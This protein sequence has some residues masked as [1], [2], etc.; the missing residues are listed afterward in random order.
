MTQNIATLWRPIFAGKPSQLQVVV[1]TQ[2]VNADTTK[3]ILACQDTYQYVD[4]V[5]IAPYFSANLT[6]QTTLDQLLGTL[7]PADISKIN[8]TLKEH[9][10]FTTP[11]N[12]KLFCYESGQGL[13]GGNSIQMNLQIAAQ[14]DP[15]MT[16]LY[17]TYL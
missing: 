1:S 3:R 11:H 12:L 17:V 2:S 13:V 8:T 9:L 5:A 16:A 14:T 4:G 10:K 15:R 6:D 7:L